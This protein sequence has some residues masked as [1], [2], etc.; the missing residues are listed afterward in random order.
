ML[1]DIHIIIYIYMLY[2]VIKYHCTVM[3]SCTVY[4]S[5]H[6]HTLAHTHPS[7]AWPVRAGV[8]ASVR[9]DKSAS[10]CRDAHATLNAAI[11][12][13]LNGPF[14]HRRRRFAAPFHSVR[15]CCFF[16]VPSRPLDAFD[17]G[18]GTLFCVLFFF[19]FLCLLLIPSAQ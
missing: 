10:G 11:N 18:P 5:T 3:R 2:N 17:P 6:A 12:L 7:A 15:P 4:A 9:S 1:R 14:A 13:I 16:L 8:S 19:F